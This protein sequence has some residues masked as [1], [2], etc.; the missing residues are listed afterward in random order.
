MQQEKFCGV[1]KEMPVPAA[2]FSYAGTWGMKRENSFSRVLSSYFKSGGLLGYQSFRNLRLRHFMRKH[3][4][5]LASHRF[6]SGN[7]WSLRICDVNQG[8]LKSRRTPT[9]EATFTPRSVV[10]TDSGN[11]SPGIIRWKML[12]FLMD[13]KKEGN[14][15][16]RNCGLI[17]MIKLPSNIIWP[18]LSLC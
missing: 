14:A 12:A 15:A 7:H 17:L 8:H 5:S 9:L 11:P 16:C 4:W 13:M 18:P 6:N 2:S 1:E 10:G 3:H